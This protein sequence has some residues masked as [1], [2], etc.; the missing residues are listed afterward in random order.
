MLF[1]KILI[2]TGFAYVIQRLISPELAFAHTWQLVTWEAWVEPLSAI[3]GNVQAHQH[4]QMVT[5]VLVLQRITAIC[6]IVE[7]LRDPGSR[8]AQVAERL[9]TKLS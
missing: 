4:T 8:A 2:V 5:A 3:L 1:I 6:L 9:H 7:A